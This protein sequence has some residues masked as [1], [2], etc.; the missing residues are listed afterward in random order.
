MNTV[1]EAQYT[2]PVPHSE[3]KGVLLAW[4]SEVWSRN[5]ST[6][7]TENISSK[8]HTHTEHEQQLPESQERCS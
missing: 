3:Y 7:L 5:V 6:F 2:C 8:T 4:M 1:L